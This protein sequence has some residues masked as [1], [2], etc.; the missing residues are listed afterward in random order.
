VPK[1]CVAI[2]AITTEQ[3]IESILKSG[4]ADLIEVRLD[5]R[6][7]QLSLSSIREVTDKPL[8]ATNRRRDQGGKAVE[9][10]SK[11]IQLL[12]EAV[13]AG[14]DYV[15]IA[16]TTESLEETHNKFVDKDVKTIISYHDFKNPL[17]M[18]T[19]VEKHLELSR[20]GSDLIKLVGWT[21]KYLDNLPYLEYNNAYP[22]NI[23]FGMGEHGIIS[24]IL[25]PLSGTAYTYASL[26]PGSELAAGQ[27]PLQLLW[28]TYRSL[29]L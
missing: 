12:F 29:R 18:E 3:T 19:L 8:I 24:R 26:D 1:I 16:S 23:S 11:K 17:N 9:S 20:N 21:D 13:E 27:I 22:G 4:L 25:A 2:Q 14:F 15:D 7:E 5:Y 6:T 28:E 10:E